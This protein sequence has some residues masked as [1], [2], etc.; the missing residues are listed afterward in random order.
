MYGQ[1]G[2]EVISVSHGSAFQKERVLAFL[3]EK[4]A[5]FTNYLSVSDDKDALIDLVDP[6]WQGNLPYTMLVAPE[7]KWCIR[8]DGIIDPLEVKKAIIGELGRYFADD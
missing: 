2:F 6:D 3:E 5:A 4:Q 7:G 8:H 1:Q